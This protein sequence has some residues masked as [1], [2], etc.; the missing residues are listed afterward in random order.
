MLKVLKLL[1]GYPDRLDT[2]EG[3]RGVQLD[4][5]RG[6]QRL[7][8]QQR[9]TGAALVRDDAE[10]RVRQRPVAQLLRRPGQPPAQARHRHRHW[11]DRGHIWLINRKYTSAFNEMKLNLFLN[12]SATWRN[13][14]LGTE[15]RRKRLRKNSHW[16]TTKQQ[17][18]LWESKI[19]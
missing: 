15:L 8:G 3:S 12:A 4:H 1:I 5:R 13:S 6:D 10:R 19:K 14:K 11:L 18:R 16:S 2:D 9:R 7:Q 17:R